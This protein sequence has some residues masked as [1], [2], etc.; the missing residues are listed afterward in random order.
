VVDRA[1]KARNRTKSRVQAKVEYCFGV[2]KRVFGFTEVHDRAPEKNADRVF[3]PGAL[4]NLFIVR[5][6]LLHA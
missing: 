3:V 5:K 4:V 1:E 6:R 2:F